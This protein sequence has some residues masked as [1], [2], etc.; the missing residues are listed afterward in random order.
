[1][2]VKQCQ[3]ASYSRGVTIHASGIM[4]PRA[5][6]PVDVEAGDECRKCEEFCHCLGHE[7]VI[8]FPTRS[9]PSDV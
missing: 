8:A 9:I 5:E 4:R 6:A 3:P 7:P 1:M 2:K